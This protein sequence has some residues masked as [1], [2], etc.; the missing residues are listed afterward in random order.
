MI[1]ALELVGGERVLEIG[2]G[3]GYAAAVLAEIASEVYTIERHPTLAES[4]RARLRQL[5]YDRVQVILGDGTRGWPEAAPFDAIVVAAGGPAI[6]PTLEGQLAHGGRL[7]IPVG[8]TPRQQELIRVRRLAAK[9]YQHE[10]M[11]QVR[12]VPLVGDL[13]WK[14]AS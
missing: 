1:E 9:Y 13:G 11:G 2:T 10:H 6:P 5:G 3:S 12:F 8:A 4:A 14:T 7:V